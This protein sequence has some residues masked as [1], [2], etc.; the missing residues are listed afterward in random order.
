MLELYDIN[1]IFSINI[2]KLSATYL[3]LNSP[4][5]KLF[6]RLWRCSTFCIAL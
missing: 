6:Y 3:F 4:L 2:N 5:V 1:P